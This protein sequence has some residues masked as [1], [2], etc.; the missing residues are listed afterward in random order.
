MTYMLHAQATPA[1]LHRL[2]RRLG[3]IRQPGKGVN[4]RAYRR[5]LHVKEDPRILQRRWRDERR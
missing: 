3:L 2:E 5:L 4:V 1:E